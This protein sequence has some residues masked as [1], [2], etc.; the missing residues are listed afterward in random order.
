MRWGRVRGY[1][2]LLREA[3]PEDVLKLIPRSYD[4]VGD[5]ALINLPKELLTYG[6]AVGEAILKV[7]KNL[8]AV[9][10]VGMTVG[11]F[12]VR[13]LTH[14]AGEDKP[15]T[16]H[17]EY[18]I[19]IC[20]DLRNAYYNPSLAEE[21]RRVANEVHDG[22]LILDLFAGV[23]PFTLHIACTKKASV[24]ANDLNP[25][26]VV[27]LRKSLEMCGK[28]IKGIVNV[29]NGDAAEVLNML[30]DETFDKA[31]LNLP[32]KSLQYVLDTYRVVKVGGTIYT[33][34]LALKESEAVT[35]VENAL[36]GVKHLVSN[37]SR[38]IDYAPRKYIY[39]VK[40]IKN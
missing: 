33:Y 4:I 19:R 28:A 38:V 25:H 18:G 27:C 10:A 9:Y 20:V 37:V 6:K 1:K 31:I 29:V 24:L 16:I 15:V 14:L 39:R 22:E 11:D 23:G 8:R 40:V 36:S 13:E 32:H 30:R 35:G 2:D 17:K 21:R 5:V 26:A 34:V 12:R 3:I 7:N